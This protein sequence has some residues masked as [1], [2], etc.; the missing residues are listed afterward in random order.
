MIW[1]MGRPSL[2]PGKSR[3]ATTCGSCVCD[4][5]WATEQRAD[6]F[7]AQGLISTAWALV[8]VRSASRFFS[9]LSSA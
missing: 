1:A 5:E 3:R 9:S 8:T 7:I 6:E 2:W 4:D